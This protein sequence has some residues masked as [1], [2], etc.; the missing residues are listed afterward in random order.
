MQELRL[1]LLECR[2]FGPIVPLA[3]LTD[4]LPDGVQCRLAKL[5]IV[6]RLEK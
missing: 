1:D 5:W 6:Q 4:K 3:E 2:V